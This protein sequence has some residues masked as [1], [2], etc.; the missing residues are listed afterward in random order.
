V[1][2]VRIEKG[3]TLEKALRIFKKKL[4]REGTLKKIKAMKHYEKPSERK[5]RKA[6]R[7]RSGRR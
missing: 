6:Q 1:A 4:D 3:D 2:E 7:A 5:K